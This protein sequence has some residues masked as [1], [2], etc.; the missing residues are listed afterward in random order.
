MIIAKPLLAEYDNGDYH[1]RLYKD[2]TKVRSGDGVPAFPESMDLKITNYCT[3]GCK[4]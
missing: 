2:G 1:V 3:V 4:W